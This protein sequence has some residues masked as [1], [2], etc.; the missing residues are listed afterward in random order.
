MM[1]D[2][3]II[4]KDKDIVGMMSKLTEQKL[5]TFRCSFDIESDPYQ[6]W[7]PRVN[8]DD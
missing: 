8:C 2:C 6:R 7:C 3:P 1:R 4:F 5:M